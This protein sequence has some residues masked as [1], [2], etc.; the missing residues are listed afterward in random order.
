M[1][2]QQDAEALHR[3]MRGMGCNE[4]T[5]INIL[6]HR[7]P[8]QIAA[9][10]QWY[11]QSYRHDLIHD[12]KDNTKGDFE[13]CVVATAMFPLTYEAQLIHNA[14]EG[15]GTNEEVL[16]ETLIRRSNMEYYNLKQAYNAMQVSSKINIF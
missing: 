13:D 5:L 11:Q 3:A 4:D 6:G 9:I 16:I 10:S 12:L 2:A 8:D 14:I 1:S 15:V 7:S